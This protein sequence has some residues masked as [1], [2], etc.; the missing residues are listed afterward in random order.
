MFRNGHE[1][2][3]LQLATLNISEKMGFQQKQAKNAG[4]DGNGNAS[5]K[6]PPSR[7][8]PWTSRKDHVR[9]PLD[10][11]AC[12]CCIKAGLAKSQLCFAE[13]VVVVSF[14]SCRCQASKNGRFSLMPDCF[15]FSRK[16]NQNRCPSQL[17]AE[18]IGSINT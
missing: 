1:L 7:E 4:L 6:H 10:T 8:A 15:E 5:A 17:T 13:D 16:A 3:P 18:C 14:V 11:N 9:A 2:K 12:G